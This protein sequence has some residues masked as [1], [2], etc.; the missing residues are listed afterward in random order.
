M[1]HY[2]D[3]STAPPKDHPDYDRL[4][5]IR[6]LTDYLKEKFKQ[7]YAEEI[8]VD[9]GMVPFRGRW[10][11][12]QYHKDKPIKWGIKTWMLCDS[13]SGYNYNYDIY[14]GRDEDFEDLSS[15]GLA[16]A[17]VLKLCQPLYSKGHTIYT[18]RFYTSP[19]L[20]I[21]LRYVGLSGC[22]TIMTNRKYFP[23]ELVKAK[24]ECKVPGESEWRMCKK[25]GLV[26]TRWVDK[27]PIYFLSNAHLPEREGI[28][29]LRT[30]KTGERVEVKATPSVVEYNKYM[31]GVDHNDKMTRIDKSRKSYKWYARV[32]RK[33]IMWAMYNAFVLYRERHP[34]KDYRDFTLDVIHDLIGKKSFKLIRKSTDGIS[35]AAATVDERLDIT[36]PHAP[37]VEPSGSHSYRC[38]VCELAFS[39]ERRQNPHLPRS[40]LKAKSVKTVF[41]CCVCNVHLCIKRDSTCWADW[42]TKPDLLDA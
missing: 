26:A 19:T 1:L 3:E 36:K 5:K 39:K 20:L 42:H 6:Y 2:T 18:D 14:C 30:T 8:S 23:K 37:A 25:T 31:G 4:Y 32:D 9:E 13:I 33:C 28:T 17:V 11:G 38:K 7:F 15:F 24:R 34:S 21:S 27:S 12:K 10:S 22:G 29:V 16:T 40:Q 41:Y 35:A